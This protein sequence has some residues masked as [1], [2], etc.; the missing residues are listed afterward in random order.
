MIRPRIKKL[1][2]LAFH[3][4]ED[5]E[6]DVRDEIRLHVELRTEQLIG[7]GMAPD[8]ARKQAERKFGSIEHVRPKLEDAATHRE[9][10]M[11]KRDW[12]ES[13]T[14]DLRYV[15]RSLRRSPTFALAV[16]VTLALGL[17]ANAALFSLL[18]RLYLQEP[19]GV[20]NAKSVVRLYS[21]YDAPDKQ[22]QTLSVLTPPTWMEIAASLPAGDQIAGYRSQT[23]TLGP[24]DDSSKG[25]VS[26]VVGDLFGTLGVRIVAGRNFTAD[27]TKPERFTPL[28]IVGARVARDKFGTEANAL[29]KPFDLG[30]HRYTIIG[31]A[32]EAFRGTELDAVD[33]WAP[34]NTNIPWVNRP[35]NP[36]YASKNSG[37]IN[38]LVRVP[39]VAGRPALAFLATEAAKR[40][41][42][43]RDT[44]SFATE[45]GPLNTMFAPGVKPGVPRSES[46]IAMRLAVVALLILVIACA[47]VANLLLARATQ[48]RREI[49]V[50]VALGVGR[51]RLVRQLLTESVVLALLAG[52]AAVLVAAWTGSALR[53]TL[54]PNV[55]WALPAVGIR[56]VAFAVA[57]A[58]VAGLTAGLAPALHASRPDLSNALRGGAREGASH[59]SL[60]R[61]GLLVTQIALS[62]VL[63]AGAGLFVR[64]L[65]MIESIDL[66][67]DDKQIVVASLNYS[68]E[69][70]HT[71]DEAALL[72]TQMGQRVARLPGVESVSQSEQLPM[73]GLSWSP[74]FYSTGDSIPRLDGAS[75][76]VSFTSPRYFATMGMHLDDGR[77]FRDD[78][79]Q[80]TEFVAVVN[81]AF[82]RVAWP[83]EPA[84]G[85]CIIVGDTKKPCRRIVGVVADSHY[86]GVI[87][88]PSMQY[89]L[90]VTQVDDD[91]KM[92]QAAAMEVRAQ[93]GQSELVAAEV[94]RLLRDNAPRGFTPMTRTLTE[95]LGPQLRPWRLGA[96]LF[97]AAGV[98]ALLVAAVG[99]YG[100][101]AYTFSQRTQEIGVR[102]A[103]GAQGSSIV[104]LVLK[105]SVALAGVGVVA[106]TGIAIWAGRFAKPL[107]YETSPDNPL[108]L[109]GVALVLLVVAVIASLVPALRAKSVDPMEALRAE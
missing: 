72:M 11:R 93:Q 15:L 69:S 4:R 24:D 39:D 22:K 35:A 5:A 58:I 50:R 25:V 13:F 19:A 37:F 77:G 65:T 105:S 106:G 81:R 90:P 84:V 34:M 43:V 41:T 2:R 33:A 3:R 74:V 21:E 18:D 55:R 32:D 47:N 70:G 79:R 17:G 30:P 98:L 67:I 82:A 12:W 78:D 102:I 87:E 40:T 46:A 71:A 6:R 26:W 56:A 23:T 54:L 108:V 61:A 104:A 80:G 14:Q 109:G 66:G 83:G 48:R 16:I 29:G 28:A 45:F 101:I 91:G 9:T 44:S 73:W 20:T 64:S 75:P 95:Q 96:A 52:V 94:L 59:R 36:W 85:K 63:L 76:F 107:L 10:V 53:A 68:R 62:C 88:P 51:S 92:P 60:L 97:T 1:F 99:I 8:E 38:T 31:V 49:G 7:G 42:I 27:E 89:F 103:L 57:T 100:T 86:G